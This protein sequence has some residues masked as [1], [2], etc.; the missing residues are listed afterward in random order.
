MYTG[1]TRTA[2]G[3]FSELQYSLSASY[4]FIEYLQIWKSGITNS[5]YD[6]LKS[7]DS[8][9]KFKIKIKQPCLN[10]CHQ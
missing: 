3:E 6:I 10:W 5:L 9:E 2:L 4:H 1:T 7:A 8:L